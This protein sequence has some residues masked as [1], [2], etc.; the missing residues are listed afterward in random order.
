M[1]WYLIDGNGTFCMVWDFGVT[2]VTIY[3]FIVIP[4]L[5]VFK[6]LYMVEEGD[7]NTNLYTIEYFIDIV[8]SFEIL[9]NFFKK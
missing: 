2:L 6:E 3:T 8:Y 1:P 9:L 5:L 4:F 7:Q